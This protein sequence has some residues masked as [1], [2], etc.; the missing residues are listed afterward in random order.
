[1]RVEHITYE[2]YNGVTKTKDF[3]FNL[4]EAEITQMELEVP[5]GLT[6]M[7]DRIVHAMDTPALVSVFKEILLRSYGEKSPDGDRFI[8]SKELSEAFSQTEAYNQLYMK[9]VTDDQL[10]SQFVNDIIPKKYAKALAEKETQIK[11]ELGHQ[12]ESVEP[13]PRLDSVR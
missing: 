6:G 3:C 13:L 10:A 1:M 8:K 4:T 2:D 7:L 9:L 5:G 12:I 11:A